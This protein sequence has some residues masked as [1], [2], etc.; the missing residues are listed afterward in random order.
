MVAP[1]RTLD[2]EVVV[3]GGGGSGLAAAIEAAVAGARVVVIEKAEFLRGSTGRSVGAIAAS[4]TPDQKRLGI[5]DCPELH[6]E[7]YRTLSGELA[8]CESEELA[9]LLVENVTESLAWLRGLGVEFFGPV[10]G[11]GH[12]VP[13]LHNALPGSRSYVHHLHKRARQ[14]GV[15][16]LLSTTAETLE[17]VGEV[18]NQVRAR[19]RDGSQVLVSSREEIIDVLPGVSSASA[20]VR[21]SR[22]VLA[23]WCSS[24]PGGS[25]ACRWAGRRPVCW[26]SA[27]RWGIRRCPARR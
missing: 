3:L 8:A 26:C 24:S 20:T 2:Y 5:S 15:T 22:G 27:G 19:S 12:S 25:R 10:E 11:P 23:G 1:S 17:Q 7:D 14:L 21:V 9:R 4:R 18:V 16:I 13:R 6:F